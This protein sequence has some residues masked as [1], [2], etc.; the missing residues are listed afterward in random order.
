MFEKE[1]FLKVEELALLLNCSTS[2]IR[3]LKREGRIPYI[4]IGRTIRFSKKDVLESLNEYNQ[5]YF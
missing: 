3:K 1:S 4:K 5:G 2:F